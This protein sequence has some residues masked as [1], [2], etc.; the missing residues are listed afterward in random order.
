MNCARLK[1]A[2]KIGISRSKASASEDPTRPA[3]TSS[4]AGR[5]SRPATSGSSPSDSEWVLRRKCRCT[6]QR[7]AAANPAA[8]SPPRHVQRRRAGAER[9]HQGEVRDHRR[10]RRHDAAEDPDLGFETRAVAEADHPPTR[11]KSTVRRKLTLRKLTRCG[12]TSPLASSPQSQRKLARVQMRTEG[13]SRPRHGSSRAGSSPAPS[14]S[15]RWRD[16]SRRFGARPAFA[17]PL[18]SHRARSRPRPHP[19]RAR[20]GASPRARP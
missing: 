11:S 2:L 17:D 12:S 19:C 18:P 15:A 14:R 20:R 9:R 1:N 5:N 13:A 10:Q 8:T 4:C 7:S 16:R 3:S 6:T